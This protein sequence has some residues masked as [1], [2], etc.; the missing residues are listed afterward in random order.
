VSRAKQVGLT[1]SVGFQIGVRKTVNTGKYAVWDFLFS[2][3]GLNI[4]LGDFGANEFE[5]GGEF[6]LQNGVMGKITVFRPYSH[7]RMISKKRGWDDDSRL[8]LRVIESYEKTVT[9]YHQ[10]MLVNSKV[11]EEMKFRWNNVLSMLSSEF[12]R[13]L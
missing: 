1:E 11:R 3:K 12:E 8:Q 5:V 9:A 2:A 13:K 10:E 4:W 6:E 7:T